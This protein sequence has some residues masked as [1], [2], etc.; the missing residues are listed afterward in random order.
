M[1]Y[2][3]GVWVDEGDG[4]E[5]VA[6]PAA[7]VAE[8][9]VVPEP[10]TALSQPYTGL[11]TE[12]L[13][14]PKADYAGYVDT[15]VDPATDPAA[16]KTGSSFVSP[17]STVSGQL[18]KI[19]AK[20]SPLQK[21]SDTRAKEQASALGMS[22]SSAAI[23]ASQRALY[24][25]AMPIATQDAKTYAD[26]QAREQDTYNTQ[27]KV[28]REAQVAGDLTI[29]KAKIAEQDK[30]ISDSFAIKLQGLD[31]DQAA[32][33]LQLKGD[34][35]VKFKEM[36][37]MLSRDL[38]QLELDA[39]VEAN[40]M[41][42]T[43]DMMNQVQISVQ[44]LLGN[45]SFLGNFTTQAEMNQAFNDLLAPVGASMV[46]AGKQAGIYDADFQSWVDELIIDASWG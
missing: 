30:K 37:H 32:G 19:F 9:P 34:W 31:A 23:G 25:S 26:A 11:A 7:T 40:M 4:P 46:M 14:A 5:P 36:D 27:A 42:Q 18:E 1:G 2:V 6:E 45:E 20:T 21:L 29:Q 10:T 39:N 38:S 8:T 17:E 43:H 16:V 3:N 35:D 33:M 24:D 41:N 22:S 44:Q 12:R 28:N 15:P 13:A